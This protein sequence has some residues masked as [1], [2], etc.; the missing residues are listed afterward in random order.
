MMGF[1]PTMFA[2]QMQNMFAGFQNMGANIQSMTQ[3]AIAD[4]IRRAQESGT[5]FNANELRPGEFRRFTG[6]DGSSRGFA[7]RYSAFPATG[8]VIDATVSIGPLLYSVTVVWA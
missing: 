1:D 8:F 4:N 2:S 7:Y 5:F 6:P 3:R